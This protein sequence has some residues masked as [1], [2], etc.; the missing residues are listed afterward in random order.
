MANPTAGTGSDVVM[1]FQGPIKVTQVL[2]SSGVVVG[3]AA[4][5]AHI[6]DTAACAAMTFAAGSI[7]TGTDMTAAEAAA[8]VTDLAALKTAIDNLNTTQDSILVALED[9]GLVADA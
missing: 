9:H 7:D 4:Q 8:I 5:K 1:D 3:G 2:N 6:A